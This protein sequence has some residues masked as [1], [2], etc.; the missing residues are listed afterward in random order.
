MLW[1]GVEL[2]INHKVDVAFPVKTVNNNQYIF[3]MLYKL[4]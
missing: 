3:Q 4:D 2:V 1:N